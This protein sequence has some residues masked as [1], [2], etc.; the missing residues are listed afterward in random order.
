MK[1]TDKPYIVRT[2]CLLSSRLISLSAS[3]FFL[4]SDSWMLMS[5]LGISWNV[6]SYYFC[7]VCGVSARGRPLASSMNETDITL[8]A[9]SQHPIFLSLSGCIRIIEIDIV[10]AINTRKFRD[11]VLSPYRPSL[12]QVIPNCWKFCCPTFSF[13]TVN[14]SYYKS[15]LTA[16]LLLVIC[17]CNV[18]NRQSL[19]AASGHLFWIRCCFPAADEEQELKALRPPSALES[20]KKHHWNH[21]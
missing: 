5:I 21:H 6:I 14:T 1:N 7:D 9:C 4:L 8:R 2:V 16:D 11:I 19:G 17:C 18:R 10:I 15:M 3:I 13:W 20:C 12:I